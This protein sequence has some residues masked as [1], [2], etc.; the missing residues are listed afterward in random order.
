MAAARCAQFGLSA[1]EY[2]VLALQPAA[3]PLPPLRPP[4]VPLLRRAARAAAAGFHASAALAFFGA[5]KNE[6]RV[7]GVGAVA[8]C[9]PAHPARLLAERGCAGRLLSAAM[10]GSQRQR[11]PLPC[12][13]SDC[14]A[15]N[16]YTWSIGEPAFLKY[17]L[18]S[19]ATLRSAAALDAEEGFSQV[20]VCVVVCVYARVC[21]T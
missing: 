3:P 13:P 21:V 10:V 6:E 5:S 4:H 20:C 8:A 18:Q 19:P 1:D 7:R 14:A 17:W 11:M 12:C 16:H 2:E 15:Q 9:P